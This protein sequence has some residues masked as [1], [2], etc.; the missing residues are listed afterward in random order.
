MRS[1]V[2]KG[3]ILASFL[4]LAAFPLWGDALAPL[5]LDEGDIIIGELAIRSTTSG[6]V[7]AAQGND[8]DSRTFLFSTR[9]TP[10]YLALREPEGILYAGSN[11]L[12]ILLPSQNLLLRWVVT[13]EEAAKSFQGPERERLLKFHRIVAMTEAL[14]GYEMVSYVPALPGLENDQLMAYTETDLSRQLRDASPW[15]GQDFDAIFSDTSDQPGG[16]SCKVSCSVECLG[17][18]SCSAN[19]PNRCAQCDCNKDLPS[20]SCTNM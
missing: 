13:T 6:Y 2:E 20:C 8:G 16:D 7:V 4:L 3:V 18:A 10:S 14:D 15:F 19:C 5:S 9:T 12:R 1:S 17:G 11:E